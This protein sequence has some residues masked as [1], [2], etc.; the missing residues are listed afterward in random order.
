M[1]KCC[2]RLKCTIH[3]YQTYMQNELHEISNLFFFRVSLRCP[4]G[5]TDLLH[6]ATT[7]CEISNQVGVFTSNTRFSI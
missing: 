2:L 6:S 7:G 4:L 5:H 3:L 1:K